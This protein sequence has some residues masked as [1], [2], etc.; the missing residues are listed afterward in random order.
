MTPGH[1]VSRKGKKHRL[2]ITCQTGHGYRQQVGTNNFLPG[3][4]SRQKVGT[5]NN[6]FPGFLPFLRVHKVSVPEVPERLYI[7]SSFIGL[8]GI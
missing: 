8:S 6:S 1:V 4:G 5:Y 3:M 7:G 2:L